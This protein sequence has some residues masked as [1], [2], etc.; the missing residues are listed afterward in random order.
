MIHTYKKSED[1]GEK[2]SNSR[3]SQNHQLFWIL[4]RILPLVFTSSSGLKFSQLDRVNYYRAEIGG[5]GHSCPRTCLSAYVRGHGHDTDKPRT[6]VSS[7]LCCR[8]I[9][10][11]SLSKNL[12]LFSSSIS[13]RFYL[14]HRFESGPLWTHE[15]IISLEYLWFSSKYTQGKTKFNHLFSVVSCDSAMTGWTYSKPIFAISSHFKEY[16]RSFSIILDNF[17]MKMGICK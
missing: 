1:W 5:P 14:W 17:G 13:K 6:R 11:G 16:L 12:P 8:G 3:H 10:R 9:T 4:P 7:D 15:R 2:Q